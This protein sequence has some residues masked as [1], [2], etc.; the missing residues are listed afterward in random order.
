MSQR[1]EEVGI[2]DKDY[3]KGVLESK[4]EEYFIRLF[5]YRKSDVINPGR[6]SGPE[7]IVDLSN[8]VKKYMD[9]LSEIL[10]DCI[11]SDED[12]NARVIENFVG[13]LYRLYKL[14]LSL[15]RGYRKSEEKQLKD[16]IKALEG[17]LKHQIKTYSKY[18]ESKLLILLSIAIT[19]VMKVVLEDI[20]ED[21]LRVHATTIG[22]LLSYFINFH[23]IITHD[24]ISG[25]IPL[26]DEKFW[27][28]ISAIN[29]L[30]L[31]YG[32]SIKPYPAD[33]SNRHQK[34]FIT[35]LI[36]GPIKALK[37]EPFIMNRI[38]SLTNIETIL[39][40][41]EE[42]KRGESR[43]FDIIIKSDRFAGY[44]GKP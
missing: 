33:P 34:G 17:D 10:K 21:I 41:A 5:L 19:E 36:C 26:K 32:V 2:C 3:Y 44:I 9:L 43:L 40:L 6:F 18:S 12:K 24:L 30:T 20:V 8:D 14:H 39:E 37:S 15:S 25:T 22:V 42:F 11:D 28:Y 1:E 27:D 29:L 31:Q 23:N 13:E 7:R 35:H 4:P 38:M 16:E